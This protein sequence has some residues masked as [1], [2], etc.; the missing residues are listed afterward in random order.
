M[1]VVLGEEDLLD[2]DLVMVR[3]ASFFAT[4]TWERDGA[5]VDL[6]GARAKCQVRRENDGELLA[7]ITAMRAKDGHR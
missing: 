2:C 3:G 6:V 4:V 5:S 7:D 1:A